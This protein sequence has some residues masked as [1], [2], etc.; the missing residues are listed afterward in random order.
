MFKTNNTRL[1]K[2]SH[3]IPKGRIIAQYFVIEIFLK[4]RFEV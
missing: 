2:E 4:L 1:F 3:H